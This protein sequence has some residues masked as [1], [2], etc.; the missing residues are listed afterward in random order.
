VAETNENVQQAAQAGT[1]GI[2]DVKLFDLAD[3]IF[4]SFRESVR[5]HVVSSINSERNKVGV[6]N[7]YYLTTTLVPFSLI[8]FG[9]VFTGLELLKD[10]V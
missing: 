1:Q 6:Q 9:F 8:Y 7:F 4:D 2:R 5:Q 10:N 3:E